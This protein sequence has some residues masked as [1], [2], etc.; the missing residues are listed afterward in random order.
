MESTLPPNDTL[1]AAA[2][3][4]HP[5]F[6]ASRR[7]FTAPL[8]PEVGAAENGRR[9]ERCGWLACRD[10]PVG[11]ASADTARGRTLAF[12]CCVAAACCLAW[13]AAARYCAWKEVISASVSRTTVARDRTLLLFLEASL[14]VP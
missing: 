4:R 11:R 8:C 7:P 1:H 10:A 2:G 13:P 12:A 5:A 3:D 9:A 6:T 14:V